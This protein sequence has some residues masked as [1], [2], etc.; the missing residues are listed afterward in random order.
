MTTGRSTAPLWSEAKASSLDETLWRGSAAPPSLIPVFSFAVAFSVGTTGDFGGRLRFEF[1]E[2]ASGTTPNAT[3]PVSGTTSTSV[4]R[5][6]STD[7][8]GIFLLDRSST[9]ARRSVGRLGDSDLVEE[10]GTGDG[11]ASD[12]RTPDDFLVSS[13]GCSV[14]GVGGTGLFLRIWTTMGVRDGR[15]DSSNDRPLNK[16]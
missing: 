7:W 13:L 14:E 9:T 8:T 1:F 10:I 2:A 6:E 12:F 4:G 16:E 15:V 3:G 5:V 11:D